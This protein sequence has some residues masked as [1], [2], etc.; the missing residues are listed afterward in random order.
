MP[1]IPRV[2]IKDALYYV[3]SRG[4]HNQNI[5]KDDEDYQTYVLLLKKY[6]EQYGID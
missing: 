6:K 4:D 1:R 3:T 5:F 2:G